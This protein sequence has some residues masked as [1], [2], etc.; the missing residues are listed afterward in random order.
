MGVP[1]HRQAEIFYKIES[2]AN[3]V[4]EFKLIFVASNL[5]FCETLGTELIT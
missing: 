4:F 3:T 5:E 2:N 1:I